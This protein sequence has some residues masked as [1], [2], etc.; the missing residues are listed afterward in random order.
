MTSLKS[1]K[2]HLLH[3]RDYAQTLSN[4]SKTFWLATT[5]KETIEDGQQ[6]NLQEVVD[7]KGQ[8]Q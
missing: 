3:S 7:L 4:I 5:K 6:K 2:K 8:L 1:L